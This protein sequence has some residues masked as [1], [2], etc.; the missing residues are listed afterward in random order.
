MTILHSPFLYP[1]Y[2][3]KMFPGMENQSAEGFVI[4]A[5]CLHPRS[6]GRLQVL[7]RDPRQP[8]LIDPAYLSDPADFPCMRHGSVLWSLFLIGVCSQISASCQSI[9]ILGKNYSTW[10]SWVNGYWSLWKWVSVDIP[11]DFDIFYLYNFSRLAVF[12]I[13]VIIPKMLIC[14]STHTAQP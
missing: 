4:L 10:K 13:L 8:P 2:F 12:L 1:Q 14:N 6:K 5:T 11:S 3:E 9:P 7:S